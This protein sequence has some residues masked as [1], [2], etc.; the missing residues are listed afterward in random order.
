MTGLEPFDPFQGGFRRNRY[1]IYER[2]RRNG[3]VHW[4]VPSVPWTNGTW[5]ICRYGHI[6][7]VLS[8]AAFAKSSA[9]RPTP[10]AGE[11]DPLSALTANWFFSID[12]PFHTRVRKAIH[13]AFRRQL[14]KALHARIES[15]TR[16]LVRN[17]KE[18]ES[19]DLV[20]DFALPLPAAVISLLVGLPDEDRERLA[21][22]SGN[23]AP[24]IDLKQSGESRRTAVG[25]VAEVLAYLDRMIAERRR[26]PRDDL[27]SDLANASTDERKLGAMVL[28]ANVAGLLVAGHETTMSLIGTGT[29]ALV[30]H[31]DQWDRLKRGKVPPATAVEELLRFGS[32]IQMTIRYARKN[33]SLDGCNIRKGEQVCLLLGAANRDPDVFTDPETLDISRIPN[34]HLAFGHGIHHCLGGS[35]AR[36]EARIAFELL[37]AEIQRMEIVGR[38]PVW[39]ES[40]LVHGLTSLPLRIT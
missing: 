36:L 12:P 18:M 24:L 19:V 37:P 26:F 35:L 6:M 14:T 4:G 40:V 20:R 38:G 31:P 21:G 39:R 28:A 23:L 32:P 13:A 29:L 15:I 1:A 9:S 8:D 5:Y 11:Q 7:S 2:Y 17:L 3:S 22:W 25:T 30:Q 16:G 34:R 10:D 27:L 33:C